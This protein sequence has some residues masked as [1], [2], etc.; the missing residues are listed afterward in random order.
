MAEQE[1]SGTQI[2]RNLGRQEYKNSGKNTSENWKGYSGD[3]AEKQGQKCF[4]IITPLH[5]KP[6]EEVCFSISFQWQIRQSVLCILG[7]LTTWRGAILP[8]DI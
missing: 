1:Q 6:R 3:S 8:H 5:L 2:K 7:S 4:I